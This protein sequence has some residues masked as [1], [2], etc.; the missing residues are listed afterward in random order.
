MENEIKVE[1]IPEFTFTNEE[2]QTRIVSYIFI[3]II[4]I[5]L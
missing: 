2:D 5:Q 3:L 4:S 1:N